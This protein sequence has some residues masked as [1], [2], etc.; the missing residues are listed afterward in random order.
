M[1]EALLRIII[2]GGSVAFV[3]QAPVDFEVFHVV[4]P[5]FNNHTLSPLLG[6]TY[7]QS[8]PPALKCISRAY[9]LHM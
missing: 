8:L 5:A 6:E 2:S 3:R 7:Q 4:W 1:H 9:R